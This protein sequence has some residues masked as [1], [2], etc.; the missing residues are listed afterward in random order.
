[1]RIFLFS[2]LIGLGAFPGR[3]QTKL[4]ETIL[5][6]EDTLQF[7]TMESILALPA[8]KDKVVFLD[9]WGTRCGPCIAEFPGLPALKE[10]YKDQP[11]VFVY[12][13]SPYGFDDS[14][15]WKA[16]VEKNKIEGIHI[17]LSIEFYMDAFWERYK[18]K[19]PERRMYTIPTY[20][21]AD[22]KGTI[23]NFFAPRP[24]DKEKLYR[25]LDKWITRK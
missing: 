25:Q 5:L 7:K 2:V 23:V 6:Y 19:Y 18:K 3:A 16:M 13:K 9:L 10:K 15:E 11:V 22:K 1:M 14:K 21:I 4:S 24:S 8:L 20:L 12:L 17:A